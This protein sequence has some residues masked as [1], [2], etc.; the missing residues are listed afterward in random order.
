MTQLSLFSRRDSS[1]RRNW[2]Q[3]NVRLLPLPFFLFFLLDPSISVRSQFIAWSDWVVKSKSSQCCS[4]SL[5]RKKRSAKC[6]KKRKEKQ[7]IEAIIFRVK[8]TEVKL[9]FNVKYNYSLPT[10]GVR[11][12]RV[13]TTWPRGMVYFSEYNFKSGL[14]RTDNKIHR[15]ITV[16]QNKIKERLEGKKVVAVN[17][18][19]SS[20]ELAYFKRLDPF[21]WIFSRAQYSYIWRKSLST[22]IK[23]WIIG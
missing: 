18:F 2:T 10:Q 8:E 11:A 19:L 13:L 23:N 20:S 9:D 6:I 15:M 16:H 7:L 21:H 22:F 4:L 5:K 1:R 12:R 17:S 14:V 3:R